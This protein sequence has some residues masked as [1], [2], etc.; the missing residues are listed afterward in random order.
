MLNV[1]ALGN[2]AIPDSMTARELLARATVSNI[3]RA[4]RHQRLRQVVPFTFQTVQKVSKTIANLSTESLAAVRA[5]VDALVKEYA[6]PYETLRERA[7][8]S[9]VH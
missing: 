5:L 7:A 2:G 4:I 3:K 9:L 1:L 8:V 6:R